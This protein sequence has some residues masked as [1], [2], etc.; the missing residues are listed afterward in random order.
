M[1]KS[2]LVNWF[3]DRYGQWEALLDEIGLARMEQP[4]VTSDWSM[5]EMVAHLTGWN[6]R[7]AD[8]MQAAHRGEPEPPPPWPADMEDEDD[9]NAW[10][11]ESNRG[12]TLAE[13]MEEMRQVHQQI[14]TVLEDQPEDVRIDFIEPKFYLVWVG[15]VRF[16]IAEFFD[17]FQDDHETDVRAWLARVEG[18][19]AGAP[20]AAA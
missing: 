1:N 2:E 3:Q 10:I 15:G 14:V 5:K 11:D 8:Q 13:V 19:Q 17:H 9:I 6:R 7:L 12:R 16:H 4:G 20:G 18:G